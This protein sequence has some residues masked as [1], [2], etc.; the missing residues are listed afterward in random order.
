[1]RLR[2]GALEK[3]AKNYID[4][5][6]L[7]NEICKWQDALRDAKQRS[8]PEPQMPRCIGEAIIRIAERLATR[9]NFRNYTWIEDLKGAGVLAAVRAVKLFDRN[10]AKRNPFGF[11]TFVIWRAFVTTIKIEKKEHAF[12]MDMLTDASIDA[13]I[14]DGYNN[15]KMSRNEMI[16]RYSQQQPD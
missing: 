15:P 5:E 14:E 10:H 8:L 11:L 3:T 9:W 16:Y 6:T 13:F 7:Y 2:R 4:K 1:M 12:K